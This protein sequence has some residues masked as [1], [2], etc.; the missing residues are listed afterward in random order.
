MAS[1]AMMPMGRSRRGL[2]VSSAAVETESKPMYVKKMMAPPVSTP[3]Q[4]LGAKGR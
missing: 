3:G 4:P 2:R 1:V